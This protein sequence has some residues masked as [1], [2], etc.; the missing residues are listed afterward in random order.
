VEHPRV[1]RTVAALGVAVLVFLALLAWFRPGEPPLRTATAPTPL[2]DR[3]QPLAGSVGAAAPVD[4]LRVDPPDAHARERVALRFLAD[5]AGMGVVQCPAPVVPVAHP[6]YGFPRSATVV[7]G[8][9]DRS[10]VFTADEPDG[11]LAV[12]HAEDDGATEVLAVLRWRTEPDGTA[13][14]DQEAPQDH[15]VRVRV[16]D[17]DGHPVSGASVEAEDLGAVA[18]TNP[19]GFALLIVPTDATVVI[20]AFADPGMS[21]AVL[22]EPDAPVVDVPLV[23]PDPGEDAHAFARRATEVFGR[24][25]RDLASALA[26]PGLPSD[27][28]DIL[29]GWD[30]ALAE[31]ERP[32]PDP[33][34]GGAV[35]DGGE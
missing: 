18:T 35:S 24:K 33:E 7:T 2:R 22:V 19:A 25:R 3:T 14:C 16:V 28:A 13:R 20:R 10:A 32:D 34:P 12:T 8:A 30:A 27:V 29:R 17:P 23:L 1:R 11:A 5:A 31:F 9:D 4:S 6:R 26:T 15:A 21:D